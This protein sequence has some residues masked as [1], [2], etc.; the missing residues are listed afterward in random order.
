MPRSKRLS[1]YNTRFVVATTTQ[2]SETLVAL[3]RRKEGGTGKGVQSR[4]VVCSD[5]LFTTRR[6]STLRSGVLKWSLQVQFGE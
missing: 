5:E 3:S 2:H 6:V 4:W 1:G